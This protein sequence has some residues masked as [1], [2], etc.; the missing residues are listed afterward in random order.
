MSSP[1]GR[2]SGLLL[3]FGGPVV[4]TPFERVGFLEQAYGLA[5]GTL[6]WR[7]PF[8]PAGDA[9]W[10]DHQAGRLSE[11]D[12][13]QVRAEEVGRA[14]GQPVALREFFAA[15]YD[16]PE[17]EVIRPEAVGLVADARAAGLAVAAL[18]NDSHHL[19]G[20]DWVEGL[21]F[22]R[23]VDAFVDGAVTGVL[24]PH[25]KAYAVALDAMGRPAAEVLFVDDQP[26][27]LAGAEA[28]GLP[29]VFF[30]V[31]NVAGSFA[32]VRRLLGL[33]SGGRAS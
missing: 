20:P 23:T 15:C 26:A 10:R 21:D 14:L 1:A 3:D 4:V 31:T 32:E 17:A 28:A 18:T 33:E 2:F 30:D 16:G 9:L 6:P 12:Y 13:W 24:K 27:N 11:R 5:P 7:G 29:A 8:D 19:H 25:P 22:V